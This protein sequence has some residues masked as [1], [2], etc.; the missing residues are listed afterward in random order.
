MKHIKTI[1][2]ISILLIANKPVNAQKLEFVSSAL[3]SG[4][5]ALLGYRIVSY[6]I[7]GMSFGY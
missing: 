2:I 7:G 4:N 6:S 3:Y 5:Q 1:C